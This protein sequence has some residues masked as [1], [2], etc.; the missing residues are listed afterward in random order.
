[1]N[2]TIMSPSDFLD[3]LSAHRR[4]IF[5]IQDMIHTSGLSRAAVYRALTRK[6]NKGSVRVDTL[7]ALAKAASTVSGGTFRVVVI[8]GP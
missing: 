8:A 4:T 5:P 3:F 2:H 1:M 6:R 7:E